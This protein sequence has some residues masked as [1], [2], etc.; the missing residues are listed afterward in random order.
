M[1]QSLTCVSNTLRPIY[2]HRIVSLDLLQSLHR[3]SLASRLSNG[4]VVIKI[5]LL[6]LYMRERRVT[7]STKLIL[8]SHVMTCLW[9][10]AT[11]KI[12]IGRM[13]RVEG[14]NVGIF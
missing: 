2:I 1:L 11:A 5:F 3:P 10:Y 4:E 7:S 13:I 6:A 8:T 14:R 9:R 12:L